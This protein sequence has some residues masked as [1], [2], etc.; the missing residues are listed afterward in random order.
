MAACAPH[1]IS[2]SSRERLHAFFP[3]RSRIALEA[4]VR[5]AIDGNESASVFVSEDT[6]ELQ[7][8]VVLASEPV[9]E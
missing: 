1:T 6:D 9:D 2:N 5:E 7:I 8:C 4:L 3:D